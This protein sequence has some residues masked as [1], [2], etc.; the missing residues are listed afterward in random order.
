MQA[1]EKCDEN[2]QK[3]AES[4]KTA[5]AAKQLVDQELAATRGREDKCLSELEETSV[6]QKNFNELKMSL[7]NAEGN[8]KKLR[9][10]LEKVSSLPDCDVRVGKAVAEHNKKHELQIKNMRDQIVDRAKSCQ[11]AVEEATK[12]ERG[13]GSGARIRNGI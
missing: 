13:E 11:L 1:A 10:E 12:K 7:K 6:L 4:L 8:E 9:E 3:C 2:E 5:E